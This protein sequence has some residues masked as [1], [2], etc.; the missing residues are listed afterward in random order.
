[1]ASLHICENGMTSSIC[2]NTTYPSI[3]LTLEPAGPPIPIG[4]YPGFAQLSD[5]ASTVNPSTVQAIL[6]TKF[7]ATSAELPTRYIS[8]SSNPGHALSVQDAGGTWWEIHPDD[9]TLEAAGAVADITQD[10]APAM[11]TVLTYMDVKN[12]GKLS[13]LER[14]YQFSTTASYSFA[15]RT[16]YPYLSISILGKGRGTSVIY[17]PYTNS[18]G[19]FN[20]L[21]GD[22]HS[23]LILKD[24][25]VVAQSPTSLGAGCGTAL[26]FQYTAPGGAPNLGSAYHA[27]IRDVSIL[28]DD[29]QTSSVSFGFFNVGIDI[30]QCGH[31]VIDNVWISGVGGANAFSASMPNSDPGWAMSV[32]IIVDGGYSP[33]IRN[34]RIVNCTTG[35]RYSNNVTNVQGLNISRNNIATAQTGVYVYHV[36]NNTPDVHLHDNGVFARDVG[37]DIISASA[38]TFIGNSM[39]SANSDGT[40]IAGG[41]YYDFRFKKCDSIVITGNNFNNFYNVYRTCILI[42]ADTVVDGA[43]FASRFLIAGNNIGDDI[44]VNT[45]WGISAVQIT[46]SAKYIEI[47][48]NFIEPAAEWSGPIINDASGNVIATFYAP[49]VIPSATL[50]GN[51]TPSATSTSI[52]WAAF[53]TKQISTNTLQMTPVSAPFQPASGWLIYCDSADG[54]LKAKAHTGTTVILGTP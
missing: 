21:F 9:V 10:C 48:H 11:E 25:S 50:A 46:S 18:T 13:L 44:G 15:A 16:S 51:L 8:V 38:C 7:T 42:D 54:K 37:F 19:P 1:M 39:S 29:V 20:V 31:S 24:F 41:T 49:M 35:I 22:A 27:I 30:T 4:Q 52:G 34:S 47:G 45:Y 3:I 2:I 23:Y 5:V 12:V 40:N 14:Q 36:T 43:N 33:H 6:V 17:V 53:G 28:N 32:G 26:K